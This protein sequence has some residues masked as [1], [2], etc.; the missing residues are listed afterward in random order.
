[1]T[2]GTNKKRA[3]FGIFRTKNKMKFFV[4]QIIIFSWFHDIF[5]VHEL[6]KKSDPE[7]KL[8]VVS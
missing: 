1:M 3:V 5:T 2:N 8:Q 6:H 7:G 4:I